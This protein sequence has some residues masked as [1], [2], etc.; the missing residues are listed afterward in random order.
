MT[1]F[2]CGGDI[3]ADYHVGCAKAAPYC[4]FSTT[5][6]AFRSQR[7]PGDPKPL[8]RGPHLAEVLVVKADGSEVRRLM[9]HRSVPMAGELDGS[10]WTTPRACISNDA[11]LLVVDSNFGEPNRQRILLVETGIK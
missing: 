11:S 4:V 8:P 6:G 10:Y 3:W 7:T 9:K 1:L 5:Y 2:H